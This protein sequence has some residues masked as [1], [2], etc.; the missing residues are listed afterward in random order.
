LQAPNPTCHEIA[1][2]IHSVHP[3]LTWPAIDIPARDCSSEVSRQ[4][5]M[6]IPRDR[7]SE[8]RKIS[9]A[10]WHYRVAR[11][12]HYSP[13]IVLRARGTR[14]LKIDFFVVALADIADVEIAR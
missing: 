8:C 7:Q 10:H 14:R 11:P 12:L 1:E 6:V 9:K 13:A 3:R 4:G 5:R 2:E